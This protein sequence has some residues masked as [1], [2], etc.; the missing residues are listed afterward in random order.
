MK[1]E[2]GLE[3]SGLINTNYL[4]DTERGLQLARI[5]Q[6][7]SEDV[8]QT[9]EISLYPFIGFYK[10]GGRL[11]WRTPSEQFTFSKRAAAAGLRVVAAEELAGNTM[12]VPYLPAAWH[13]DEYLRDRPTYQS[14]LVNQ[15]FTDVQRAHSRGFVYGDR[16]GP[17]I[18]VT[19]QVAGQPEVMHIDFDMEIS[20]PTANELEIAELT[21]TVL[22]ASETSIRPLARWLGMPRPWFNLDTVSRYLTNQVVLWERDGY[23]RTPGDL[24]ER[25]LT[26]AY[27]F[28]ANQPIPSGTIDPGRLAVTGLWLSGNGSSSL[29][30]GS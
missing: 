6:H 12:Y 28:R 24:T 11:R 16:F 22:D 9:W 5:P 26:E 21:R 10:D 7:S 13:L 27:A 20:G 23:R 14:Q 17:N 29:S 3:L 30:P 19:E 4:H 1:V 15:L 2:H 18:L 25:L 8:K